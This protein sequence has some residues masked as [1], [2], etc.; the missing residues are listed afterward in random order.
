MLIKALNS[1][2]AIIPQDTDGAG[3]QGEETDE[4]TE[5]DNTNEETGQ[6]KGDRCNMSG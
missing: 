5:T 6:G 4:T 1:Q 3:G 2:L